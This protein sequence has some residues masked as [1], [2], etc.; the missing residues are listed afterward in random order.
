MP[1]KKSSLKRSGLSKTWIKK[2]AVAKKK[3]MPRGSMGSGIIKLKPQIKTKKAKRRTQ[4]S[5]F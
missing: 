2:Q 4:V 3:L 1:S 5:H